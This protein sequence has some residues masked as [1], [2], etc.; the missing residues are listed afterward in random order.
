MK[1][2]DRITDEVFYVER[3]DADFA[4]YNG[5]TGYGSVRILHAPFIFGIY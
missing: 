1:F 2:V 3:C 4:H 5:E